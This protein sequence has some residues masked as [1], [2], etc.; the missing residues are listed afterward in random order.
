MLLWLLIALGTLVSLVPTS[1]Y[2]VETG[3]GPTSQQESDILWT[4]GQK[5]FDTGAYQDAV[6]DL[7][8]LV[9]RYPGSTGYLEAHRL[10]GRSLMLL[11]RTAEAIA[12]L[13][14]YIT[15]TGNRELGLTTR[16]WLGDAYLQFQNRTKPISRLSKSKKQRKARSRTFLRAPNFSKPVPW[17][18]SIRTYAL[19]GSSIPSRPFRSFNRTRR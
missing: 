3:N 6:N 14:A 12:P 4:D 17:S 10:L 16:L 2:A 11:G 1:A 7:S 15:A 19:I 13:Q 9:D 5:A 8:R 18:A